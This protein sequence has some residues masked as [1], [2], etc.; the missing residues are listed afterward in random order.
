MAAVVVCHSSSSSLGRFASVTRSV[1]TSR[2]RWTFC[3][4]TTVKLRFNRSLTGTKHVLQLL[5]SSIQFAKDLLHEGR[6]DLTNT[7]TCSACFFATLH[8]VRLFFCFGYRAGVVASMAPTTTTDSHNSSAAK[9][10]LDVRV[11][12]SNARNKERSLRTE[13]YPH[14]KCFNSGYLPVSKLHTLY[15]EESGNATGQVSRLLVHG[16][17]K[18]MDQKKRYLVLCRW[19]SYLR[20]CDEKICFLRKCFLSF[21]IASTTASLNEIGSFAI[22]STV[23]SVKEILISIQQSVLIDFLFLQAVVFLHGGPG[24]GTSSGNRRF[25]DPDFYRIVLFDQVREDLVVVG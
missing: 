14:I 15:W 25:F 1:D 20:L 17:K 8:T 12:S 4:T 18:E 22:A 9:P 11:T 24:S 23:V 16:Q 10:D 5:L 21:A 13:L 7:Y 19:N 3:V 6:Q 2:P